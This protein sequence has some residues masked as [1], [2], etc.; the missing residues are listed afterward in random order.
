MLFT[1]MTEH[2]CDKYP[3][4]IYITVLQSN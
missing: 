3:S 1:K 4:I 2:Y